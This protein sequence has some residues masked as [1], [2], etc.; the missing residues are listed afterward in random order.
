MACLPGHGATNAARNQAVSAAATGQATQEASSRAGASVVAAT[1][2]PA[3]SR[4]SSTTWAARGGVSAR[5]K[6][7]Q[8]PTG[9]PDRSAAITNRANPR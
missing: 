4:A 7:P 1:T 3:A 8:V 9:V 5:A 2:A 6:Q